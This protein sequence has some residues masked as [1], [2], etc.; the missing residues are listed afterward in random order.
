[1]VVNYECKIFM[2]LGARPILRA[3]LIHVSKLAYF[4][5]TTTTAAAAVA[6]V[7]RL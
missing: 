7:K 1:M 6:A 5:T 3:L 2:T 4:T